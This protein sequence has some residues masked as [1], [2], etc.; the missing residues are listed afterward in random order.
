MSH[1]ILASELRD[2]GVKSSNFRKNRITIK[3]EQ[4]KRYIKSVATSGSYY[5]K[6]FCNP[7]IILDVELG[8]KLVF[9]DCKIS[10]HT[11][12]NEIIV[13]WS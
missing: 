11:S 1:Q 4:S 8:L 12:K 9:P 2:L 10:I 7:D 5:V 3:I 6:I 13:D